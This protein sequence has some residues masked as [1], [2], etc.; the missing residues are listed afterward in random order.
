MTKSHPVVSQDLADE[1]P[2]MALTWLPLA[3]QQRDPMIARA[4]QESLN[5]SLEPWLLGHAV[6]ASVAVLI[7]IRL[8]RWPAAKLLPEEEI[9]RTGPAKRRVELL[10]IEVRGYTR[11]RVGPHVHDHL[12]ALSP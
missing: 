8:P 6:V 1:Q 12:N 2:A 10:A 7:I 11:V 5:R 9:A 4:A 3:T